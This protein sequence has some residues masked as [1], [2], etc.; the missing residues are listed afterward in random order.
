MTPRAS[1]SGAPLP[2]TSHTDTLTQPPP[3]APS[4]PP[5]TNSNTNSNSGSFAQAA[6]QAAAAAG[7][8]GGGAAS[9]ARTSRNTAGNSAAAREREDVAARVDENPGAQVV[10]FWESVNM[11]DPLSVIT[12]REVSVT[13]E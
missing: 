12:C 2:R 8:A 3:P 11:D 5:Q 9:P 7:G 6:A 4:T 1:L 10:A 13:Y